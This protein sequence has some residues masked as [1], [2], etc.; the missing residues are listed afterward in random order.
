MENQ[1][2]II[3][4]LWNNYAN[5]MYRYKKDPSAF[6][7]PSSTAPAS[8]GGQTL[9]VCHSN[10]DEIALWMR[11]PTEQISTEVGN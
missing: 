6:E 8:L 10:S 3:N 9:V 4:L 5:Q 1:V 2:S 11:V 7:L